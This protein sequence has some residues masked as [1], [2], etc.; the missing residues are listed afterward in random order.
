MTHPLPPGHLPAECPTRLAP[1]LIELCFQTAGIAEIARTGRMGLPDRIDRVVP[2]SSDDA[3]EQ[4]LFAVVTPHTD[5]SFDAHVVDGAGVVHVALR[6]Y[7][8][9]ELPAPVAAEQIAPL[10]AVAG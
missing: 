8:T 1:R 4:R 5:G 3:A 7:R 2:G 6:G 10:Q 9:V